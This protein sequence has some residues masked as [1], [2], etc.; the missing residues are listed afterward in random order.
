MVLYEITDNVLDIAELDLII[1][2]KYL[3]LANII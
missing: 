1:L 3:L 2:L